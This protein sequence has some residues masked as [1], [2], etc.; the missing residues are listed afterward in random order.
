MRGGISLGYADDVFCGRVKQL[1]EKFEAVVFT[2]LETDGV[3]IQGY[4]SGLFE[5]DAGAKAL[6]RL[7]NGVGMGARGRHVG[8][9]PFDEQTL[10]WS[11]KGLLSNDLLRDDKKAILEEFLKD[12]VARGEICDVLNMQY[13]DLENWQWDAEDEGMWVEP[14][15]QLNGKTRIMMDEDVLQ[16]IFLHYIGMCESS[17]PPLPPGCSYV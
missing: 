6:A 12:E 11:L 4:L 14:R 8:A 5:G 17:P 9:C 2:P 1:K 7:R 10:V 15:R 16:A 3:E 13:A